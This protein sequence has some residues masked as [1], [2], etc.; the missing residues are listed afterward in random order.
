MC[1]RTVLRTKTPK[2]HARVAARKSRGFTLI[3][4]VV[5]LTLVSVLAMVAVPLYEVTVT[6]SKESELRSALREIRTALDAYKTA[7]DTG[8]I[9]KGLADSGYPPTL[10]TLVEGVDTI[11]TPINGAGGGNPSSTNGAPGFGGANGFGASGGFGGGAG[12]GGFGSG[13]G[14]ASGSPQGG[15]P[16]SVTP[17]AIPSHM[18]FLRQV[19]RDPFFEDQ[20]VPPDQQWNLRAYGAMPGDF[21]GGADVYDVTTKSTATGLNG[22]AYKDW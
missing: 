8:V 21:S 16:A 10:K 4:L 7:A 11:A 22:I 1:S 5:T 15:S 12:G 13:S 9:S 20:S 3:E 14:I 2:G 19:P 18:V 17:D 6:R